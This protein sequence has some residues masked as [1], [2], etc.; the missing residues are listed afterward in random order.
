VATPSEKLE[1]P[2]FYMWQILE[3]PGVAK[4]ITDER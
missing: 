4:E 1:T 3:G 2:Y